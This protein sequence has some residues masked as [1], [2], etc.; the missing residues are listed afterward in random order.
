[1]DVWGIHLTGVER[2]LGQWN[3][4]M[5]ASTTLSLLGSFRLGSRLMQTARTTWNGSV[6]FGAI[7]TN[8]ETSLRASRSAWRILTVPGFE[9]RRELPN[10]SFLARA[11]TEPSDEV[12]GR[13]RKR[14]D[15]QSLD[16]PEPMAGPLASKARTSAWMADGAIGAWPSG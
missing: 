9:Y 14:S 11:L 1:M 3:V 4:P 10:P 5:P 6:R 7:V 16:T 15:P 2:R 13:A 12:A 8:I